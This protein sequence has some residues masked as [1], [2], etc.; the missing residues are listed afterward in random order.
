MSK[1]FYISLMALLT[2]SL[3]V[4]L[5]TYQFCQFLDRQSA[6]SLLRDFLFLDL[7]YIATTLVVAALFVVYRFHEHATWPIVS[8]CVQLLYLSF[9]CATVFSFYSDPVHF[10]ESKRAVWERCDHNE[11]NRQYKC[12][13]FDAGARCGP[14]ELP[15]SRA[16]A[17]RLA[18]HLMTEASWQLSLAVVHIGAMA[19][20]WATHCL[21]GIEFDQTPQN[22]PIGNKHEYV[23]MAQPQ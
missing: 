12:C 11:I 17:K 19:A 3:A 2:S 15:C 20:I 7:S 16:I 10:F 23:Q 14:G 9:L 4:G 1:V 21:G 22:Q 6:S 8:T 5:S 18:R 13:G